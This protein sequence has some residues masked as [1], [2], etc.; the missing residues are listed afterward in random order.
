M[1]N[2]SSKDVNRI[3]TACKDYATN[4]GSEWMYDEYQT[5][6]KKLC[7]YLDQNFDSNV[8]QPTE[9]SIT[10]KDDE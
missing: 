2:L 8:D 1:Y 10:N 9:C 4:T 3:I 5:I 7:I 6:I